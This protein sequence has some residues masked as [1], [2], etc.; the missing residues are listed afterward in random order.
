MK[1]FKLSEIITIITCIASLVTSVIF[2]TWF[3][4][5]IEKRVS[6]V[7]QT[8]NELQLHTNEFIQYSKDKNDRQ[9]EKLDKF[10]IYLMQ[11]KSVCN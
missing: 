10:Y 5:G 1:N 6:L 3:A 8:V 11:K 7:E 4:A 2:L 9:D